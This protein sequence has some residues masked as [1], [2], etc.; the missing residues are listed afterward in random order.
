MAE[1]VS[2]RFKEHELEH[3]SKLSEAKKMDKTT[4]ARELIEFGWTYYI[5][6]QYKAGRISL[7]SAAK[8]L[9]V[10]LSDF[11]DLLADVGIK[12]PITYD[13]YLEGLKNVL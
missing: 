4:A 2:F 1:V 5:L 11:I 7:E 10:S 8:E 13:D 3:I 9:H 12:S 6:D